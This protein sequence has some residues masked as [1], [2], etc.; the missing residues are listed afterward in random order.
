MPGVC[1]RER[2]AG[3]TIRQA[4]IVST[5]LATVAAGLAACAPA[6]HDPV[7]VSP[8]TPVKAQEQEEPAET[9]PALDDAPKDA[10]I[11]WSLPAGYGSG[12]GTASGRDAFYR[13][14][15]PSERPPLR[16]STEWRDNLQEGRLQTIERKLSGPEYRRRQPSAENPRGR[17]SD[18]RNTP[19]DIERRTLEFRLRSPGGDPSRYR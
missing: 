14:R 10:L 12:L 3:R 19:L 8:E 11:D 16:S 1:D 2:P 4:A 7:S 5:F 18:P 9:T 17:R 6:K 13:L 15:P